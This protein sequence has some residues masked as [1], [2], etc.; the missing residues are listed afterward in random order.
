[1]KRP[2]E[3]RASVP[4]GRSEDVAPADDCGLAD[5]IGAEPPE[6]AARLLT[7]VAAPVA[8][9]EQGLER[10]DAVGAEQ[11][12]LSPSLVCAVGVEGTWPSEKP[13]GRTPCFVSIYG[14]IELW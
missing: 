7:P 8:A 11:V 12:H 2:Q 14:S 13:E 10:Q 5:L 4:Q 3:N 9:P 1:M 6:H